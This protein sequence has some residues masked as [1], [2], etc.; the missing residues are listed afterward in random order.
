M[1]TL[2]DYKNKRI[3]FI[4]SIAEELRL[5][6]FDVKT[7]SDLEIEMDSIGGKVKMSPDG[8]STIMAEYYRFISHYGSRLFSWGLENRLKEQ[9]NN[10][11]P[12]G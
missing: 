9:N 7:N 8:T 6:G 4:I 11:C 1:K 3:D 10:P 12:Q 2:E 5:N